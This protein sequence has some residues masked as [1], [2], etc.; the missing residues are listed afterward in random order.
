MQYYYYE[1]KEVMVK[2][3]INVKVYSTEFINKK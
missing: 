3:D 2:Y 1:Y